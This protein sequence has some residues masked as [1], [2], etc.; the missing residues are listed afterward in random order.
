MIFEPHAAGTRVPETAD[1]GARF[2]NPS[3]IEFGSAGNEV[4]NGRV[5][6]SVQFAKHAVPYDRP[7]RLTACGV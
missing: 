7:K 3:L 1:F 2:N 4:T 5:M 6:L